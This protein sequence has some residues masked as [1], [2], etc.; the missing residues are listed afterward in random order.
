MRGRN[1]WQ[2]SKFR[3]VI[4][5]K[6]EERPDTMIN[7]IVVAIITVKLKEELSMVCECETF[8]GR[9]PLDL[10]DPRK[11]VLGGHGIVEIGFC[12]HS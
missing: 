9:S 6:P 8:L 2:N 12:H 3:R 4:C 7:K 5:V 10:Y 1:D 11:D